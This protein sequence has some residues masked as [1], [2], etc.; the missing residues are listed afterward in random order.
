ML[1]IL[2]HSYHFP[3]ITTSDAPDCCRGRANPLV[4]LEQISLPSKYAYQTMADIKRDQE[5]NLFCFKSL[6][7]LNGIAHKE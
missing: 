4:I 2:S 1:S 5:V 7:V 3:V 6:G